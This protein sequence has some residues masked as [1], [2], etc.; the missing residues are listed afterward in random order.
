MLGAAC[1]VDCAS[2]DARRDRCRILSGLVRYTRKKRRG[3]IVRGCGRSVKGDS[4]Q[5][6]DDWGNRDMEL[7][8]TFG[9]SGARKKAKSSTVGSS[10]FS[11]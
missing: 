11:L 1:A 4:L 7:K 6:G 10:L 2:C 3:G 5:V 9:K 8:F